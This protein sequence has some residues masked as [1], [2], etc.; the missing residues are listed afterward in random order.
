MFET[1]LNQSKILDQ[2][3]GVWVLALLVFTRCIAFASTAPLLGHKSIP[4]LARVAFSIMLTLM[5]FP[6]LETPNVF[7][8][9]FNFVYLIAMNVFIGMMIGWVTNLVI[10]IAKTAGEM[11]DMQLGLQSATM[12]DPG[13]QS[14]TTIIGKFF[15]VIALTLFISI[16]GIEKVIEGFYKSYQVFPIILYHFDINYLKL[17]KSAG[18]LISISFLIVSPIIII[19]LSVDLILGLMSRAAP[20]IN[21]FQISFSIKP[22]VGLVLI[23]ILL[24]AIFQVFASLFSNPFRFW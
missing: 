22:T 16:G 7:P 5:I 8:K 17:F 1:L 20:Q 12:F 21:A 19:V 15:D 2:L 6:L 18:D 24:P 3:G 14:Q 4:S 10:E 11:L 23:L 9:G 13:S